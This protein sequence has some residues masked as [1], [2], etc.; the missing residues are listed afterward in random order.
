MALSDS[1]VAVIK[2]EL[3]YNQ[4]TIGALPY[5]DY[6]ALFDEVVQPR[7][8]EGAST[9]SSTVVTAASTPTPVNLTLTSATGFTAGDR[10]IVDVDSLQEE[11]TIRSLAGSVIGVI[12]TLAHTGTYPVT[13]MGGAQ[14]V[15]ALLKRLAALRTQLDSVVSTAGLKRAEDIEWYQAQAGAYGGSAQLAALYAQRDDLRDQ[16]AVACGLMNRYKFFGGGR[17]AT[18][19]VLF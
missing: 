12:L 16:L 5:V 11:A 14:I 6:T 1:E 13:V 2:A 18:T 3:G 4:L 10:V 19:S 17:V 7:M 8:G 9:T 15:R